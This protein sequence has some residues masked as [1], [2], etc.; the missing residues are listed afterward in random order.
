MTF[1]STVLLYTYISRFSVN[2]QHQQKRNIRQSCCHKFCPKPLFIPIFN[3]SHK[4]PTFAFT[5]ESGYTLGSRRKIAHSGLHGETRAFRTGPLSLPSTRTARSRTSPG[6]VSE[7]RT[8]PLW[9]LGREVLSKDTESL[10]SSDA[11]M[12]VAVPRRRGPAGQRDPVSALLIM[13]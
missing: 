10:R 1:D 11:L 9:D 13:W 12:R 5:G 2:P 8:L 3:F 4:W 7:R 6:R